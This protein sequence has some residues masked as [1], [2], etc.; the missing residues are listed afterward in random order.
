MKRTQQLSVIFLLLVFATQI[1]SGQSTTPPGRVPVLPSTRPVTRF[2]SI[3]FKDV[4]AHEV[5]RP[6]ATEIE[7][8]D[9]PQLPPPMRKGVPIHTSAAGKVKALSTPSFGTGISPPPVK[10]FKAEF[11]SS[12]SIPPDTMGAVGTTHVVTVTNDR[13]RI[14]TRDGIEISRMTLTSFWAGVTI[15]GAAIS[16]FDPKVYFDRFNNRFILISSGNGAGI[17][18]GAMFAVSATA[19]PTG[20]WYRWSV[21]ADPTSTGVPGGSGNWIDYP[22]VGHNKNWIVVNENVFTYSCNASSCASNGFWGQQIYVLDKQAAYS[23]TLG[24]IN[25]FAA[26]FNGP[27]CTTSAT[28]ETE[29]GCGFTMAPAI[30]EDN[31]TDTEYMVEDW[32]SQAGQLRLSKI[33]GTPSAPLLTVGTQF[34]QS[35]ESWRF[36]AARL[37]T[38]NNC[39]G[40]CSGGYAPQRQ[41][42]ANLPS[43]QRVMTNDSRVQNAVL[44]G[45]TL[46]CAHTV[47]LAAASQPAGTQIGSAGN[48][49]DTHSGIQWWAID[50]TN[51]TGG[52]LAPLQR[53]RIHDPTA[54]NCHN[55]TGGTSAVA[56]CNGTTTAQFGEFFAYPN[57]SVN[58]NNDV[59]IGFTRFS[60]ITY[61]NSGYVIRRSGDA[62]N[63]TRDPVVFRPGQ[64]NYNIGGGSGTARQNRWG[65][66]SSAQTDPLNDSDFW[67]VQEYAGTV[68]DFGI[69]LAGNWETWW[70][71]VSPAAT[72]PT[73]SGSLIISEFRLRGPQGARDEFV[74]LYNPGS[75]PL[76]VST[77]DGSEGWA[78][79][80][81]TNGTTVANVFAV[82]PNGT[83]IPAHGHFLVADN[84]DGANGPTVVYGLSGAACT[85]A[86][87]ADSDTGWSLDLADNGGIALFNTSTTANF[88]AGTRLDS[89]GFSSIAA[90]LFKEG[91]GIPAITTSTPTGQMTFYRDLSSGTPKD[92]GANES[93]FIFANSVVGETLGSAPRLGAAGPENLSSPIYG[94]GAST[95]PATLLDLGVGKGTA[96]NLLRDATVVTNGAFGTL[97]FRRTF[98]NNTGASLPR[99]RFRVIDMTTSPAAGANADLRVLSAGSTVVS[100]SGGGTANVGATTLETPPTQSAGGGL[101]GSIT[102]PAVTLATPLAGGATTNLQFTV[103]V[104]VTGNY[105]F[106][107]V[108]EGVPATTSST[109]CFAGTTEN[110]APSITPSPISRTGGAGASSSTIATVSDAQDAAGSLTVTAISVP[111]GISVTGITNTSGTITAMVSASCAAA[112]GANN[113]ILQVIDSEGATSNATLVVTVTPTPAPTTPTISGP[114]SA[115]PASPAT[116][117]ANSTGAVSYQWYLNGPG[118]PIAGQTASTLVVTAAGSYTVTATNNCGT[119][120]QSA[121]YVVTDASPATPTITPT[122]ASVCASSTGNSAAG[123]AGATS[124]AWS[125]SNGTITSATNIQT[126]TYT[127]GASG[128]VG[129][130]LVVTNASGCSASN[131]ANVTINANPAAPAITPTPAAVCASSTGNSAAGPAGATSYAWSISNGTITS[132]TN[133]QTITYTAGASGTVGLTLVVT[134]ASGCSA[135]NTSNVTI[136]S[137]PNATIT[138]AASTTSGSTGN[139]ASVANAGGGATY[140]WTVTGG[141]LTGGNNTPSITYTAGAVGTLTINVTVTN[142]S[143]CS[144]AKSANVTVNPPPVTVTSVSPVAGTVAGG[145]AVTINGTG[146]AAGATVT[147]GG[148]AATNVVVVS[149]IKITVRTPAHA[150]GSVNVTVTNTDTSNGTLTNGYLFKAQ[151]FDPNNDGTISPMDIFYLVNYLYMG[152]PAPAGASGLLSGDANGD[153]VVNPLD[154]FYLVNYLFLGGPRPNSIIDAP[155]VTATSVGTEAPQLAGS[156]ALGKAVLRNGHY[157]VPVIMTAGNGS[158][159]PQA[160][161]LRV[162]FDGE[163][164]NA[165]IRKAGAA[166]DLAVA[167]ET[168]RLAGNDL[169]YLISYGNLFLG[170]SHSAVVAEIEIEASN[171]TLSIDPQL[172]MLSNQAGTMTASVSN[173][174]L[175]VAGTKIGNGSAQQPRTPELKVN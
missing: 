134:N 53:G 48:P 98:T 111:A 104:Q 127:A 164:G 142:G 61:P 69:G 100:V 59:F 41:Q 136:N 7:E 110:T 172:T 147:F 171:A 169:S 32:D 22:T 15:K 140:A 132:A 18:S 119:S 66:Y 21:A 37:G 24:S 105:N 57:I 156:I 82:V 33:T 23:N 36:D 77:T 31:T 49:I 58:Q 160:M 73:A 26:A 1:V 144:D 2:P 114:T 17:N 137:K 121:P 109:L 88:A 113:V 158:I 65:D 130:T 87:G 161:S 70:T 99:L 103:G 170:A 52:A 131:T 143:G 13:M 90:G 117:T 60:P 148:S 159:A 139:I 163:V 124:Y 165:T 83:V 116:L 157:V 86:R 112:G 95:L 35:T 120:A 128:T 123:P 74:E 78:L 28:P 19:D 44:R 9:A 122:P 62:V 64:A 101:N 118:N 149:S 42:S 67:T 4:A 12:T 154:I 125:I 97:S 5:M 63:T 71:Q 89:A 133:I 3:N 81:S 68:R 106:C 93:D 107:L 54:N 25:L 11:L 145:S 39:G 96:P 174:K 40:T 50:P 108:P 47:M 138:A 8:I 6:Q 146:F 76:I 91:N 151:Q 38:T 115:C 168:D 55:G 43:S 152:G 34:P 92:T 10:T 141:T 30:T 135:T 56:P 75:Q 167:F 173:G 14:Q 45:G 155:H 150:A 20:V 126:I 27:T 166:K 129:L 94:N 51:E 175:Q 153:G 102:V 84:P 46:W 16:A 72:A 79:A 80:N 85:E 29:L 162:H